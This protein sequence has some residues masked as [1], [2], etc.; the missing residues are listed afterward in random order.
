MTT[1]KDNQLSVVVTAVESNTPVGLTMEQS[2]AAIRAG[3]P[4]FREHQPYM[5]IVREYDV[6]EDPIQVASNGRISAFDWGRLFDLI[7]GPLTS[8]VEMSGLGRAEMA[9]GG[10]YFA[11]PANDEVVKKFDLRR[12]F[13]EQASE[14]LA[15]PVT[16]EFLGVQTGSTGAYVLVERAMEKMQAGEMNFCIIAAVDSYL[17]DDRLNFYDRNWRLKTDRNAAGFIPGEAGAVFLLETEEF[18]RQR[19]AP[20]LMRIDGV[21]GDQEL[22]PVTG[23]KT[24]TGSGLA[25]AIEPLAELSNNGQPWR[26]VLSDLNGERYKAY[27]WGLVLPR[28]NKLFAD[29]HQLSYIAD[30]IGDVGA[31]MAAVQIGYISNAFERGFAPADSA[32]LFAGNDA[33]KRYAMTISRMQ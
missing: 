26:W 12:L 4:G 22:N 14:R 27:E 7:T 10:L 28:L 2:S 6:A 30:V 17:L 8:L 16:K 1:Q 33:G 5:P 23:A 13:L 11:L 20:I 3:I 29:N 32:L 25:G 9:K 15:L 18:A 21:H 19:K 31:A 24:S